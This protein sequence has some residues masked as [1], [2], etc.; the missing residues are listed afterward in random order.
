M[1]ERIILSEINFKKIAEHLSK[2][3]A[4]EIKKRKAKKAILGLSGGLD[5]SVVLKLLTL[6]LPTEKIHPVFMPYKTTAKSSHDDALLMC[7]MLKLT[8]ETKEIAPQV[9]AYFQRE[10]DA[11]RIRFGNKCAR[12]RM[13]VLYDISMREKGIVIGT[14]NRSEIIMGYGTI[15]GDLACAVNPLGNLY[16]SQIFLLAKFLG[17]P[18]KIINKKPSADLWKGQTDEK[19]MGI[20]Y[21]TIDE[22]A[23][24]CFDR[25]KNMN[26]IIKLGYKK[27]DIETIMKRFESNAFK[28]EM[29]LII[30]L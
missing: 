16:K 10:K 18:K 24:L 9:D 13:S 3:L 6:S 14:S 25:K 27:S 15:F 28:R 26:E 20:S 5:S 8:L 19:E 21:K 29:P 12:E 17:I 22:I 11:D 23:F 2:E 1:T 7:S 30:K 4:L